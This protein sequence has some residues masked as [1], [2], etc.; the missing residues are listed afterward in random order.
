M[1]LGPDLIALLT[2]LQGLDPI[3]L[4]GLLGNPAG[5]AGDAPG[6]N[7]APAV[8]V[9]PIG[10]RV[11]VSLPPLTILE[12]F[13]PP[14]ADPLLP[15]YGTLIPPFAR[16]YP[17]NQVDRLADVLSFTEEERPILVVGVIRDSIPKLTPLWGPTQHLDLPYART[18]I[19]DAHVFFCRDVVQGNL[20]ASTTFS[21]DWLVTESVELLNEALFESKLEAS[22]LGAAL[23]Q[24]APATIGGTPT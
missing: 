12:K 1:E 6:G 4:D 20:P 8:P 17:G 11:V 14:T 5:A 10:A 9:P 3:V 16:I 24:N 15:H 19:H 23:S 2:R 7:L 13:G 18:K 21:G 22:P